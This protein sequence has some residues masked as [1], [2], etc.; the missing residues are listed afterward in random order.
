MNELA[1][2]LDYL[3]VAVFA[4]TGGL[5]ASDK[6]MDLVGFVLV[7]TVTGIGGGTLRDL[8]LGVRPVFWI[9]RNE[10]VLIC[11]LIAIATFFFAR[12]VARHERCVL[13]ADAVGLATFC[14][15][16]AATALAAGA[17]FLVAIVMGV[18]TGCFGGILRD[19]L[20]AEIPIILRREI[21]ATAA[22]AGAATY[23]GLLA[24]TG[25]AALAIIGGF[26]VALTARG[27]GIAFDLRLPTYKTAARRD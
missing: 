4:A 5:K 19:V 15:S 12:H 8:L 21:Y 24:L 22:A 25:T 6:D 7:A 13:W 10:Y 23:V 11:G 3:G 27:A 26:I 17:S 14:V 1:M 2:A 9:I 18:M 16:G 20:C